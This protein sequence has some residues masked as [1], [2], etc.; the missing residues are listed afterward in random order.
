MIQ[1][2]NNLVVVYITKPY[3]PGYMKKLVN[4]WLNESDDANTKVKLSSSRHRSHIA[5]RITEPLDTM[6]IIVSTRYRIHNTEN[7]LHLNHKL[8]PF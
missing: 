2:P 8:H 1:W 5:N 7:M 3:T 6:E 4:N